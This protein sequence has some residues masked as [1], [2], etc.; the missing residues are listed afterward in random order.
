MKLIKVPFSGA[1]LNVP[2]GSETAP[3]K[4]VESIKNIF[5]NELGRKNNFTVEQ[6]P[7]DNHNIEETNK[8]IHDFMT[9]NDDFSI[10]IGGDH[11]ITY[12]SFK[13]FAEN[14]K[15]PGL[16]V[17]DAHADL[18]NNFN[19]PTHE[20][21]LK[22]LI[23][24]GILKS[25]N[26]VVVGLRNWHDNEYFYLKNKKLKFFTMKDIFEEGIRE[27]CDTIMFL[28]KNFG[29]LYISVDIDVLDPAFAPGT[30][31]KEAGGL[32]T[33]ELLYFL[34]RIRKLPNYKMADLVEVNPKLDS[35][36]ITVRAGA[37]IITELFPE[38]T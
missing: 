37:K 10:L 23:E 18:E 27:T 3:D 22:V 29:S 11:S 20:D 38:K 5:L 28:A 13:A 21:Y 15:N 26:V 16:V 33:R 17:F 32:T 12:S 35:S 19:P 30:G 9:N 25:S 4:I 8:N 36:E 7:V 14:F 34:Q 6:I 2:K 1:T 31:Y 24:E